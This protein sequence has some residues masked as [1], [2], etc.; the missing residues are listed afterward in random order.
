MLCILGLKCLLCPCGWTFFLKIV[1]F[2]LKKEKS[3]ILTL[4]FSYHLLSKGPPSSSS[5]SVF[6]AVPGVPRLPPGKKPPGPPPGPPPPQVLA[7]Y[8]IP[9]RRSYGAD[10]GMTYFFFF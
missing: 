4:F 8:G 6:A 2:G 9:T 7:L 5:G 3:I 10:A 1:F